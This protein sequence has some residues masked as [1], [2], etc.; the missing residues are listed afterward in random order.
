MPRTATGPA[1]T[2]A[3]L[4]TGCSSGIGHATALRLA[5]RGHLVHATARRPEALDDLAAAGCRILPLDVTD[6]ASMRAAVAAVEAEHGRVGVLVNNAGWGQYGAI[7]EVDLDDVRRQFE[8]NVLGLARMCQLVLPAM[9]AAGRG[10]IINV[11]SM[12]GRLTFPGGGYYHAS[13]HAVEALSDAL[14][15]EV[16]GFGVRV[17][18]I[19]PGL[20]RTGFGD[21]AHETHP[22]PT[23][24]SAYAGFTAASQAAIASSYRG[25]LAGKPEAVA[26]AVERAATAHRPRTRYQVTLGARLMITARKWLPDVAWD[27]AMATAFP[28]PGAASK[29]EAKV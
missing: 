7:E 10:R 22:E 26:R 27:A 1:D 4:V 13:K 5:S 17:A 9:R 21:T 20:I 6:E 3:V 8:T 18:V 19:E 11:S 24:D 16:A 29:G 23:G 15:F 14:R 12:G 25:P 2:G 28:R